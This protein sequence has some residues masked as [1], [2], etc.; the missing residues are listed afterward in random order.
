MKALGEICCVDCRGTHRVGVNEEGLLVKLGPCPPLPRCRVNTCT[1]LATWEG[2]YQGGGALHAQKIKVCADH[3][4]ILR[5][6]TL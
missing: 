5:G 1:K 6:G 4:S 3:R 2:W